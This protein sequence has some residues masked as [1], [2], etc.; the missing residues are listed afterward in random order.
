M[1]Q[2][3]SICR[4]SNQ[5]N[6]EKQPDVDMIDAEPHA[7]E[8]QSEVFN[9]EQTE[10]LLDTINS[11]ESQLAGLKSKNIELTKQLERQLP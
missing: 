5:R 10:K 2:Y 6:D 8:G 7:Q 9:Q 4:S 3:T 1:E 11:L